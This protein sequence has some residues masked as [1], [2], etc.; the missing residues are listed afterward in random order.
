MM[1]LVL[2]AFVV[3]VIGGCQRRIFVDMPNGYHLFAA[4]PREI[5]LTN[6]QDEAIVG[7]AISRAG[8]A[9]DIVVIECIDA[10]EPTSNFTNMPGYSIVD[11][12]S[13]EV[14]ASLD[15]AEFEYKAKQLAISTSVLRPLADFF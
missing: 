5:Y 4:N 13:G 9:G 11:T 10:D 2:A 15:R 14:D 12:R 8:V 7:Y 3:L 6:A 1:R